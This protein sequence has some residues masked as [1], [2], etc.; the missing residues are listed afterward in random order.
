MGFPRKLKQMALFVDGAWIAENISMTLPKLA[1]KFEEY[2]GGGMGGAVGVDMG[3]DGLLEA[4]WSCGGWVRD[5]LRQ[6]GAS[7]SGTQLRFVGSLEND[8]TG[9][10]TSVE[11]VMRGR[12][13]EIDLGE[14]KPGEDTEMKIK[15]VLAYYKL[16]WNGATDIEIDRL[17]MIEIVGGVDLMAGHR[18]NL[19][20]L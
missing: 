7:I 5:V 6:Y 14:S 11:V 8:D 10:L 9:E 17:G 12:H 4:Q 15:S 13:Q 16:D 18:A 20:F 3:A 19:G 2:R 1:R